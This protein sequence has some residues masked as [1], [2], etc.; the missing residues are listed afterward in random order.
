MVRT[1]LAPSN[2][3][4]PSPAASSSLFPAYTKP[5]SSEA[6]LTETQTTWLKQMV[7]QHGPAF[8]RDEWVTKFRADNAKAMP[9]PASA[10][11]PAPLP[12]SRPP[13]PEI[14]PMPP[15]PVAPTSKDPRE[16][17]KYKAE[18]DAYSTWYTKWGEA[19][20]AKEEKK[21]SKAK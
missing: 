20:A 13:S 19:Y 7:A 14:P 11:A 17:A 18:Y 6:D 9:A 15:F 2:T 4:S 16:Y 1:S 3:F 8:S 12:M 21:K 10:P 5:G